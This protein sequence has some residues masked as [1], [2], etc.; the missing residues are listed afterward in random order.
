LLFLDWN[1]GFAM[2]IN[3][4]DDEDFFARE[5]GDVEPMD[6][7]KKHT[8]KRHNTSA[9]ALQARREAAI[10]ELGGDANHL[11][12]DHVELLDAYYPLEF[13]RSGV[14][15]GVFRKLKQGKYPQEG[16][17]DLH[18]MTIETARREVFEFIVESS[19]YDLRS[20][21]I[22]HGKGSHVKGRSD[23]GVWAKA[24]GSKD[25]QGKPDIALLKSYVN[26]WLQDMQQVQAFCS[27]QP[28]HGG[29]GAVYV[30]L[31]KSERKKQQNRD[32]ISRGRVVVDG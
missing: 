31:G 29:M 2:A 3:E 17:L 4:G 22:I 20:L 23:K 30:L 27:A 11:L 5:M 32:R 7:E 10:T 13:K 19:C 18:R 25:S 24:G 16:R 21:I 8:I 28:Q 1:N 14:Q 12:N 6:I 15:Q 9:L 26:N